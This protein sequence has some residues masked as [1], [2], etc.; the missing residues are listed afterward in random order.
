MG[1]RESWN[2]LGTGGKILVGLAVGV[3][4]LAVLLVVL[5]VLAAVLASFVLGVGDE[6]AQTTPTVS[7]DFDYDDSTTTTTI[8]HEMGDSI[9]A[10]QLRVVVGERRVGWADGGG[11]VSGDDGEVV[12]GD[13]ITVDTQPGD[14]I[15]VVYDG[16]DTTSTL[17]AHE[18]HEVTVTAS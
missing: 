8:R 10:S 4:L 15:S 18:I 17:A 14:R 1:I 9:P 12:A 13:S 11:A 7:F 5:V 2:E 6:A 16:P 3:V